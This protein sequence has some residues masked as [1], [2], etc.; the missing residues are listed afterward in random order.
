MFYPKIVGGHRGGI[1]HLMSLILLLTCLT[2]SSSAAFSAISSLSLADS[3]RIWRGIPEVTIEL[4]D[5]DYKYCQLCV[6]DTYWNSGIADEICKYHG[7]EGSMVIKDDTTPSEPDFFLDGYA[8]CNRI[9]N[10]NFPLECEFRESCDRV[11]TISC[12]IPG[13]IGCYTET[14]SNPF[15]SDGVE[16]NITAQS[17]DIRI[18][19]LACASSPYLGLTKGQDCI[20]GSTLGDR[21]LEGDCDL[22]CQED[23]LQICGGSNSI[24]VYNGG[25]EVPPDPGSAAPAEVL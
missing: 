24:S 8:V 2:S 5:Q 17:P 11:P 18:C 4:S 19:T 14:A 10:S 13:Y 16:P 3:P 22:G 6:D 21:S 20:C 7:F 25:G 12:I 9:E 15:F 23:D 1:H